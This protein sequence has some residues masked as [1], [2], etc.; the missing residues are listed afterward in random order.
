MRNLCEALV[1]KWVLNLTKVVNTCFQIDAP[2]LLA[3]AN[4]GVDQSQDLVQGVDVWLVSQ[5]DLACSILTFFLITDLHLLTETVTN[6][7]R[8][9]DLYGMIVVDQNIFS[10]EL[11]AVNPIYGLH[12]LL[13]LPDFHLPDRTDMDPDF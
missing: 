8:W 13:T 6:V 3:D 5:V 4:A 11:D 9:W 12:H 10:S 2:I 7:D 1:E